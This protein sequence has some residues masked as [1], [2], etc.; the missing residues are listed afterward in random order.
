MTPQNDALPVPTASTMFLKRIREGLS[1]RQLVTILH[2]Y[3]VCRSSHF[4]PPRQL[5]SILLFS[6]SVITSTAFISTLSAICHAQH[7]PSRNTPTFT[8]ISLHEHYYLLNTFIH[9]NAFPRVD[10]SSSR[11]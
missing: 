3:L 6:N 11:P 9:A 4:V 7:Y 1:L 8:N 5:L 10:F 2:T